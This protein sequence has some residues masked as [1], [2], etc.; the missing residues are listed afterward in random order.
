[1]L[2]ERRIIF[3]EDFFQNPF[4]GFSKNIAP[5]MK[6]CSD[7]H[8]NQR[9]IEDYQR[10]S[11]LRI[12]TTI[13]SLK[14]HLGQIS[15]SSQE[16][17]TTNASRIRAYT[18]DLF[19]FFA[20]DCNDD[21]KDV[22]AKNNRLI[23]GKLLDEGDFLNIVQGTLSANG[24]NWEKAETHFSQLLQTYLQETTTPNSENTVSSADILEETVNMWNLL[25]KVRVALIRKAHK[26]LTLQIRT[27]SVSAE[28]YFA[29]QKILE[30]ESSDVAMD[31]T[32]DFLAIMEHV[33]QIER[34]ESPFSSEETHLQTHIPTTKSDAFFTTQNGKEGLQKVAQRIK[35]NAFRSLEQDASI[36]LKRHTELL[37]NIKL[38]FKEN[39]IDDIKDKIFDY[40]AEKNSKIIDSQIQTYLGFF[41]PK[42]LTQKISQWVLGGET[43]KR[44]SKKEF[45]KIKT[46][47]GQIVRIR[48]NFIRENK[49]LAERIRKRLEKIQNGGFRAIAQN[50]Q[51]AKKI[52]EALKTDMTH[53]RQRTNK[54][55]ADIGKMTGLKME[56]AEAGETTHWRSLLVSLGMLGGAY[57]GY[58]LMRR[59]ITS[60]VT[61]MEGGL[62]FLGTAGSALLIFPNGNIADGRLYDDE[63]N[64]I[65]HPSSE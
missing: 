6:N 46:H 25:Q 21:H 62:A 7:C 59:V 3:F 52:F 53:F 33:Q 12:D 64:P 27:K 20:E 49:E 22:L 55:Y 56:A 37:D 40:I 50:P 48:E 51:E 60:P 45:E 31:G 39:Y 28:E 17:T 47:F 4:E 9:T 11:G 58:K 65:Y 2:L 36:A 24:T 54:L 63:G 1:M 44:V 34:G 23:Q 14:H 19:L 8:D 29:R 16:A 41:L 42:T 61:L 26:N 13:A 38:S 15:A 5:E 57:A 30:A 32:K 43:S 35:E 18:F 10:L